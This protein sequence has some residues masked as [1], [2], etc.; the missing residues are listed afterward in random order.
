MV[1]P[2]GKADPAKRRYVMYKGKELLLIDY[3]N[4]DAQTCIDQINYNNASLKAEGDAGKR[5]TLQLV[6][7]T[8][9][10]G[11]PEVIDALKAAAK[12]M[13]PYTKKTAVIGV[14]GI[15]KVLINAVNMFS[16][17]GAR[18]FDTPEEGKEWLIK[19]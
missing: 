1:A 9:T 13:Q 12:L 15:K 18:T 7:V 10:F 16:G 2:T 11:T 19:D 14:V 17:L 6:D 3:S 8:G 5:D 4:M